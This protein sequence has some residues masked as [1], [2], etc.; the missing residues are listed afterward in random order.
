MIRGA[1]ALALVLKI[2]NTGNPENCPKP[3]YCYS[4]ENY[5]LAVST[6]LTLVM[7]TTLLFGTFMDPVQKFL[8]PPKKGSKHPY[9]SGMGSGLLTPEMMQRGQSFDIKASGAS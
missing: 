4:K 5:E 7:L 1:I 6:T 9:H 8:V 2:P 3:E